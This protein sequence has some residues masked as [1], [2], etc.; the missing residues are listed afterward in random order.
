M[1]SKDLKKAIDSF[2]SPGDYLPIICEDKNALLVF[3]VPKSEPEAL[4]PDSIFVNASQL[5]L[6]SNLFYEEKTPIR[7]LP[8]G[9]TFEITRDKVHKCASVRQ[10]KIA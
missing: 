9:P 3:R 8:D 2:V 6:P 10:Q 4:P 7:N 1:Q 5:R